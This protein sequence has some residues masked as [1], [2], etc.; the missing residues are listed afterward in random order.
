MPRYRRGSG[1]V[2]RPKGRKTYMLGYYV[3]GR[4]VRQSSGTRD[5]AEARALLQQRLAEAASGRLVIGAD[6]VKFEDLI[7]ELV[8]DYRRNRYRSLE[9]TERRIRLHRR[10]GSGW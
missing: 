4:R 7:P 6:R 2:W 1:S 10:P 9:D 8:Q 5:I 3:G